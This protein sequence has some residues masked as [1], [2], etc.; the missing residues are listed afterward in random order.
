MN[1]ALL[2]ILDHCQ[3]MAHRSGQ[4]IEADNDEDVSRGELSEQP[5]QDWSGARCP[6]AMLLIDP[7]AAGGP[8]LV[9]LGIV[10]LVVRRHAGIAD[11]PL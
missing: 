2:E 5:R 9:H 1:P 10:D 6:R 8:Q 11:Q 3:E 4:S 7:I